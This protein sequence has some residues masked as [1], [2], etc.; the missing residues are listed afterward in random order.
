MLTSS[1]M[2]PM[3][4]NPPLRGVVELKINQFNELK[5]DFKARYGIGTPGPTN[6]NLFER[7]ATLIRNIKQYDSYLE[8][9]DDL[10]IISR[11]VEN[12]HDSAISHEKLVSLEK[13]IMNKLY[14]QFNRYE[15]TALHFDLMKE[16]IESAQPGRSPS[17][18]L[19]ALS[20]ED[21]FEVVEDGLEALWEKFE[22]E[23]FTAKD[24]DVEALEAYLAGIM[25]SNGSSEDLDELRDDMRRYGEDI[26]DGEGEIDEDVLE[27]CIMDLLEN[28][29]LSDEKKKTLEGYIQSQV[30][31]KE[32]LGVLNMKSIRQWSWKC[33]NKGIPVTAHQDAEGQY[34]II[35]DED[36]IDTLFLHCVAV[37]WAQKL[38]T[39]LSDYIRY[40]DRN[41]RRSLSSAD[42][43]EQ[44]FF[45]ETMPFEPPPPPPEPCPE[46]LECPLPPPPPP[47]PNVGFPPG[48][49]A[50]PPYA[51]N[52]MKK[53]IPKA[54]PGPMCVVPP[55]PP[56]PFPIG[57]PPPPPPPP[58]SI[59][60]MSPDTLDNERHRAYKAYFFMSRLPSE[61]GCR[62]K[63]VPS[64]EVQANL[65]KTLAAEI[66]L[67]AVFDDQ[68]IC[69]VVDFHSLT[70]A[71][72]H[73]TVLETL[74]FL[75][76]PKVLTD[77]FAR[78]LAV[79]LNIG[80]SVRGTRDRV[81]T[82]ACGVPER[83]GLELLF[84]E[85]VMFFAELAVMK[86][87]GLPMYR[88][89]SRCYF[90]GT[91]EHSDAALQELAIFA[92]HT[93]L[94]FDDVSVQPEHLHIG[95]LELSADALTINQSA[96][97]NYA[98]RIKKQLAAQTNV[99]DWVRIWNSTVGTYAAHLFGPL[100]DLFGKDHLC[101]VK[102]AYHKIFGIV[103][104]SGTDLTD[105]V[106]RMLCTR[107]DFA[108]TILPLTL[109]AI[110]YLPQS[111]GGLGVQNPLI[112]LN[113]ARNVHAEPDAA[114]K[115][116]LDVEA[117][118]HDAA[119]RNWSTLT[120]DNITKKHAAV[121]AGSNDH[122]IASSRG[123]DSSPIA[124]MTKEALT[125]HRE[126]T[127]FPH[128][129]YTL[130][131]EYD[132]LFTRFPLQNPQIP[133]LL[134]LYQALLNEPTDNVIAS[135]RIRDEAREYG[136]C[137]RWEELSKEDQWV[138]TMYGDECLERFG[139]LDVWCERYVPMIA[140]AM[141]RGV[142]G[143]VYE[144]GSSCS[145]MSSVS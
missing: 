118:Y 9:D 34:H 121:F 88:L 105:H 96:V 132:Q 120:P 133:H 13:Q 124:F 46:V 116:Y 108:R 94:E 10:T 36:L 135:E 139:G 84:T 21:D 122:A 48:M 136:L 129:P 93:K 27:W 2:T 109:E 145:N 128:L 25:E 57:A 112:P 77:F 71:L 83:H 56:L 4:I 33:T 50:I 70:T 1:V 89:G 45:L 82:R 3:A 7:I 43:K 90:V 47:P 19:N 107:S 17:S 26:L 87:V 127:L 61:D 97:E 15:T 140:M 123:A 99:Y 113:L 78:Y 85:A 58:M 35:V 52:K 38:K 106:R 69:S 80:P 22:A 137:K 144:D 119:L 64:Q 63:V 40:T 51:K 142:E 6:V 141:V 102:A 18:G 32:L 86:K 16:V 67:R 42:R 138:L 74:K 8:V 41:N 5:E 125:R 134:G 131:H 72:P 101:L 73:E 91:E 130:L 20:L 24:V 68:P 55:P 30:A 65:I 11:Y 95:F 103:F 126:Y 23:A 31:V 62:P 59:F 115:K 44:E 29:L 14:K 111:F 49:W 60:H 66:K 143:R 98:L 81:L 117:K 53:K 76:V 12:V 39:C 54:Y 37:G 100:I 79:K 28:D 92:Q 114:I 75:G 104:E 110:I